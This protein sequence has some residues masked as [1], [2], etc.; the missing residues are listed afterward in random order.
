MDEIRNRGYFISRTHFKLTG[1]RTD[2]PLDE[3]KQL[4]LDIK[5]DKL[6]PEK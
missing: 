4:I 5:E 2:M 6:G 3:L 1:M